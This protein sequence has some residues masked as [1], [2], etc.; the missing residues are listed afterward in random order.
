VP[1]ATDPAARAAELR[2]LL[3]HHDYRYYAL[4]DP[5]ASDAQYDVLKRE[6]L[7][8]EAAHPDVVTPDSPTQRVGSAPAVQFAPVTHRE[9]LF[10]LD[11]AMAEEELDAWVGRVEKA[12]GRPAG[13]Y[14]CEPKID[15]LAVSLTYEEGRFV[16]GATRGDGGTGEDI[17]ANLRTVGAIPLALM[18]GGFPD[19]MEV[20]GEVYMPLAAFEELNRAQAE[21]GERV[22]VNPRNAAAGAVR[23][24]DPAVTATRRL[25]IWVYQVGFRRGGPAFA[26][27]GESLAWLREAGFP[28]NPLSQHCADPVAVRAYVHRAEAARHDLP[29]QTD[30]VV[31]KVDSLAEQGELGFTARSPRWAVAY[32]Y[33][34]EEETTRLLAIEVNV[35]RTGAV[36]PYAVLEPVFVGGATITNATLHNQDE[37]ARKDL[38]VG[39]TVVIRRAGE[40]IPEVVGPVPSLRTGAEKPWSMPTECPFCGSP[41][42]RHEGEAVARCTGGFACPS[43][44]REYLM[45]FA[46]RGGMDIEGLGYKTIDM[47]L[48][49][50]LIAD[51]ADIFSLG[52]NDLISRERWGE[53]SVGNLLGAIDAARDRPLARVLTALGI[54]QVGSTVARVLA[55]RLRR[56]EA[57]LAASAEELGTIEGIGPEIAGSLRAWAEDPD[58]RRL[59]SKL[60]E[61]GVRLEDPGEAGVDRGLLAGVTV[62]VTGTL[63]GFSRDEARA[64]VEDRGGK[65]AGSVSKKTTAVVVGESPGSKAQKAHELGVPVL[66]EAAF[67][68]LLAEGP[69]A[70]G[71]GA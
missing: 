17:T 39:D 43:R 11:N 35:G 28:V 67:L 34:P 20:R 40:V 22:F 48:R 29:Y 61:A 9:R 24:K 46:G 12:L 3:R 7:A 60:A 68:R 8:L 65:V 64:A 16:L 26:G 21:A 56:L 37:I 10:S 63:E 57:V 70:L 4:D 51:P 49:E 47:L 44:L 42:V 52:K 36:T 45:H 41:I 33:P 31:V 19:V 58:N 27:H 53:V 25:S 66:D 30:G 50:G 14:A 32:K 1:P 5:E 54:P 6:L 59:V 55:R 13:G 18:G 69:A 71:T 15:G 62:V 38:R 2:A 23:Q